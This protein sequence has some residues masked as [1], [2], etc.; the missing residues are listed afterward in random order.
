MNTSLQLNA[1]LKQQLALTPS[2]QQS[3]ALLNLNGMALNGYLREHWADNP[4]LVWP[5]TTSRREDTKTIDGYVYEKHQGEESWD[6]FA[7]YIGDGPTLYEHLERELR[8]LSIP[9]ELEKTA[10]LIIDSLDDQGY[11]REDI[12]LFAKRHHLSLRNVEEALQIVQSLD[13]PGV[14]A[15]TL[16]ECLRLQVLQMDPV[17]H[18]LLTIIDH[19]L[20]DVAAKKEARIAEATRQSL[21]AVRTSIQALRQLNPKPGSIFPN[22][23]VIYRQP[24]ARVLEEDGEIVITWYDHYLPQLVDRSAWGRFIV[25]EAQAH[26]PYDPHKDDHHAMRWQERFQEART[27]IAQL[28]KRKQTM[29]QIIH[30]LAYYQREFFQSGFGHLRPLTMQTVA[31]ALGMST[32]TISR[33]VQH[34]SIETRWGIVELKRLFVSATGNNATDVSAD[35]T[36]Q[37]LKEIIVAEDKSKPLS[38]EKLAHLLEERGIRIARRTIAK[39]RQLAGI[40]PAHMRRLS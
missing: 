13:P 29:F 20:E 27:L 34:K 22:S 17:D 2:M 5:D 38:D 24:E 25:A 4:F 26:D 18:L 36:I 32:S 8:L 6:P 10:R 30:T 9:S 21:E 7:T 11:F 33:A 39:Y 40:P 14:G 19:H 28:E 1:E 35:Q 16:Q 15:R 23:P 37:M 31:D 12:E 3:L